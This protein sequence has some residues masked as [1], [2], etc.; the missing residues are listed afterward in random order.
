M[1]YLLKR[2]FTASRISSGKFHDRT[3]SKIITLLYVGGGRV[4]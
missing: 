4:Q 1:V 3:F 2:E